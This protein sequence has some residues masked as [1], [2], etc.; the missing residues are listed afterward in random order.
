[1]IKI[2]ELNDIKEHVEKLEQ[3]VGKLKDGMDGWVKQVNNQDYFKKI[4]SA[5]EGIAEDISTLHEM[6]EEVKSD[7]STLRKAIHLDL[8]F[9]RESQIFLI[10]KES[11]KIKQEALECEREISRLI[12]ERRQNTTEEQVK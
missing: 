3:D 10:R 7:V 11:L 2:E 4:D 6:F 8:R 9:I 1:V 5:F 12:D